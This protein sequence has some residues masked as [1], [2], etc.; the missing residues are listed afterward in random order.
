MK[1]RLKIILTCCGLLA[2]SVVLLL[3]FLLSTGDNKE[4]SL[5]C[6]VAD[7][8]MNVDDKV[9]N[10]YEVSNSEAEISFA[11]SEQNIIE[12]NKDF[13]YG[14]S[15]GEVTVTMTAV[16]KDQKSE[17]SFVVKVFAHNDYR[18]EITSVDNCYLEGNTIYAQSDT[19][20]I[21]VDVYDSLNNL[22]LDFKYDIETSGETLV[23]KNLYYVILR[24]TGDCVLT[25]RVD[26][27]GIETTLNVVI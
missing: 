21:K 13:I 24:I 19:I 26:D 9:Y 11:V 7:V 23:S 17:T 6:S 1:N 14:K 18:V 16:Y 25:I 27:L 10:F 15:A 22:V 2:V 5:Y 20:Q 8:E 4:R 12:I 3:V